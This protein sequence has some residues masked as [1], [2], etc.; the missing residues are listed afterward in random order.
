MGENDNCSLQNTNICDQIITSGAKL[1]NDKYATQ[2]RNKVY[3]LID[4]CD[5]MIN[6]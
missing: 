6:F 1:G 3:K 2:N 4:E 5:K